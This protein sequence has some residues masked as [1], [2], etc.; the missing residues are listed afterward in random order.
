MKEKE[1]R[2]Q[3]CVYKIIVPNWLSS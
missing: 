1:D 3:A 2:D